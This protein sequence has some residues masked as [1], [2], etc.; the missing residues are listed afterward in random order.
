MRRC[1]LLRLTMTLRG[2]VMRLQIALAR[3]EAQQS[4]HGMLHAV[5]SL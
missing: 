2:A 5:H 3:G 4:A 1:E